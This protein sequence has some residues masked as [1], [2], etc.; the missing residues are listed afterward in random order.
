MY[1]CTCTCMYMY[2]NIPDVHCGTV[3]IHSNVMYMRVFVNRIV[4]MK[5]FPSY[6][7]N[8]RYHYGNH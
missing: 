3:N 2:M 5:M 8:H 4:Q 7:E 1:N 6:K